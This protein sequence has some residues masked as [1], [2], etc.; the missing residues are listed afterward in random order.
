M[1][2]L[3][4]LL[5]LCFT[6]FASAQ[7]I[8]AQTGNIVYVTSTNNS[9]PPPNGDWA[10]HVWTGFVGTTSNGGGFSGGNIPGWNSTTGTFIFG[11]TQSTISYSTAVNMA[12]ANAGTNIQINGFKYSW[13]Y[14]NQ[15]MSRGTLTGNIGLTNSSGQLIQ[16]YAYNMP[17]TTNGW[18]TMSGTQN[19]PT[20]YALSNVG[21]L[22]VS[23]TGKDDRFWAGYY[24]PQIRAIDV[25]MLYSTPVPNF[26]TWTPLVNENGTF[27]LSS[28]GIVRYGAEGTYIYKSY[29]PGTYDCSNGAFGQ[30]PIGGVYKSC[31]LGTY[32]SP[33]PTPSPI[34]TPAP[35]V[36]TATTT[37]INE[38]TTAAAQ[39]ATTSP[40]TSEVT[41]TNTGVTSASLSAPAPTVT[42]AASTQTS[43]A[44]S[45]ATS[46]T[47]AVATVAT[48]TP[49]S[50]GSRT[51]DGTGIGLSVVSRNAQ[52]EQS[53]AMQAAQNAVA[54]AEQTAQSAQQEAVSVAQ[55]SSP[56]SV[57]GSSN[58][59]ARI[60]LTTQR[61]EQTTV[62]SQ[63][64]QAT[65]ALASF[66][67]P[68]QQTNM[69]R[70]SDTN[71]FGTGTS[72][73]TE[74]GFVQSTPINIAAQE[75]STTT[76]TQTSF[77][78]LPPQQPQQV[79]TQTTPIFVSDA[80]QTPQSFLSVSQQSIFTTNDLAISESQK[81]LTDRTNPINEIIEGRSIELP[82]TS[83][84]QQRTTVNT[85][86]SDN[87]IAGG[88][89]INRMA[90]S[91]VGYNQYLNLV[92]ADASFYAPK[93]IYKG[94]K[95]VDNVR[96]LRQMSLD[97][98]HQEMVN[99]QYRK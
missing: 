50:G 11:Y 2:K 81:S 44:T 18:T 38:I 42:T 63:S 73:A 28:S 37:A 14:Y 10:G 95:N 76:Q 25:K 49:S 58:P 30:D 87:E 57:A 80:V 94:Q 16:N 84:V 54:A 12:L 13:Q 17:Q 96:A 68:G 36:N 77:A 32:S 98:L 85:N 62:Q 82:T 33:T 3:V 88:V 91:P 7:Q 74:I 69:A 59:V 31:S 79:I 48:T 52:R 64:T 41:T 99:Q 78:L 83:T 93:E 90:T 97:R 24:G 27:T 66:A 6:V 92:I 29:E 4:A 40:T 53:I 9:N 65:T 21:N 75:Q 71:R 46:T 39:P 72:V 61:S 51:V 5:L 55:S 43:S 20:Q 56:A 47:T 89:N 22:N 60:N 1:K 67:Q 15:D 35:T 23:F 86:V 19:F 26:S 70:S 8:D 34:P 45:S